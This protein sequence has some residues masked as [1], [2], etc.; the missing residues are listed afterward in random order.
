[1][2]LFLK[3]KTRLILFYG[4]IDCRYFKGTIYKIEA[5]KKL[6]LNAFPNDLRH[7]KINNQYLHRYLYK[8]YFLT[9]I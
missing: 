2:I 6:Q 1:M 9:L 8:I 5:T 4:L 7:T 3:N